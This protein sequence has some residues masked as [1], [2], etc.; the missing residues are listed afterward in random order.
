MPK[1][2]KSKTVFLFLA[3]AVF[4]TSLSILSGRLWGGKPESIPEI[5]E[6]KINQ[7][8]TVEEFGKANSLPNPVLKEIFSLKSK[9]DLDKKLSE[10]GTPGQLKSRVTKKLALAAEHG[11]KNW[12]KILIKFLMWF[13]FLFSVYFL[14]K[15]RKVTQKKRKI[16]L[17]ISLI[18]FGVILGSDPGPMGT[19]KDAIHLLGTTGVIFPPRII[20]LVVFLLMVFI[21]NK[22]ICAWGCQA[23]TLQDLVF[24]LNRTGKMEGVIG[25]Q[26]KVPFFISNSIRIIF[27][28]VFTVVAFTLGTD[29]IAPIDPFKIYSPLHL[30][31][32]GIVFTGLVLILGLFVYRPWCHF[33]CPFGLAG[34]LVEKISRIKISVN[35]DTCIACG[36]C[37]S[38]CP[39]T[40]MG[41]ILRR[42]KKIIP[43]CF[44]CY[45]CREVC[46]TDSISFSKRKRTLPP[47][48]HFEKK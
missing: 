9:S 12:I 48:G 2:S 18:I 33:F 35:Y 31:I 42:D 29:I 14:F 43:D 17:F 37:E 15:K 45:T 46:P 5:S 19:V 28:A 20:A 34:W 26:V 44:A 24:R 39:S 47:E 27:L 8:M 7:N 25:R 13:V 4:V 22:F 16:T 21:A 41:A 36:K 11:S 23:G 10:F 40:V 38:A 1:S 30:G 3:L 6:L 32:I